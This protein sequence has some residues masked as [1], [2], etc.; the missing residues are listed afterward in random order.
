MCVKMLFEK[1]KKLM[2]IKEKWGIKLIYS[3]LCGSPEDFV[4]KAIIGA[5]FWFRN[6]WTMFVN[7]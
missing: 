2:A 7:E 6:L 3:L 4:H 5:R 1:A